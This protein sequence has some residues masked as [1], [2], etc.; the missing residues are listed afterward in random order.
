MSQPTR[1]RG[2]VAAYTG[3]LATAALIGGS[4]AYASQPT[5]TYTGCLVNGN[6]QNVAVGDSPRSS[7]GNPGMQ[8]SWNAQGVKGD[9]GPQG[10]QGEQGPQ[11]EQGEQGPQGE[12]GAPGVTGATGPI[13]PEGPAGPAG[14]AGPVGQQGPQGEQGLQGATGPIGPAGP[15]GP[16]GPQGLQGDQGPQGD[17]GEKGEPGGVSAWSLVG[18]LAGTNATYRASMGPYVNIPAGQ[19]RTFNGQCLAG[20]HA[21]GTTYTAVDNTTSQ[22]NAAAADLVITSSY[23]QEL[24]GITGW[25]LTVVN[26]GT[27]E[28][29]AI[30]EVICLRHSP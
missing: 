12:Q 14:P 3:V 17:P 13:G 2:R 29:R 16:A 22:S 27:A 26:T 28:P 19:S 9:Q 7:C 6:I 23:R 30:A 10:E 1:S 4:F 25:F 8:I 15:A 21:L 11:G 24:G 20:D 5:T 18:V